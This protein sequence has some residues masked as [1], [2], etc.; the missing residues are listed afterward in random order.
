MGI[1]AVH[2]GDLDGDGDPDVLAASYDAGTITWCVRNRQSAFTTQTVLGPVVVIRIEGYK[3]AHSSQKGHHGRC[4]VSAVA[5]V[6][7]SGTK[8]YQTP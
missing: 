6:G 5:Q 8:N 4:L 3:T 1:R 7:A 2:V